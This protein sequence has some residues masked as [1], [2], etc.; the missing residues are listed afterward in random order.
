VLRCSGRPSTTHTPN[1]RSSSTE[2]DYQRQ[3]A[4]SAS[5][6][7]S[8]RSDCSISSKCAVTSMEFQMYSDIQLSRME[9]SVNWYIFT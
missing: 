7:S 2:A 3:V 4:D 5:Q 8:D 9:I 1:A 6:Q